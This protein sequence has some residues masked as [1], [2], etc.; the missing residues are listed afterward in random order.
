MIHPRDL[1]FY[2]GG[3]AL[4]KYGTFLRRTWPA[5]LGG[6]ERLETVTRATRGTWV[7]PDTFIRE[8]NTGVLRVET[9]S[10]LPYT[11]HEA[12]R[13]QVATNPQSPNSWTNI[14]TPIITP[15]QADPFGGTDAILIEDDD[16]AGPEGKHTTCVFT[17]DGTK[18]VEVVLAPGSMAAPRLAVFDNTAGVARHDVSVTWNGGTTPPTVATVTGSGTIFPS[19]RLA[20]GLWKIRITATGV[21]AANT[22]QLRVFGGSVATGTFYLAGGNAFDNTYPSSWQG[23]SLASRNADQV[24]VPHPFVPAAMT[25]YSRFVERAQPNWVTVG[26]VA[27]RML[28]IGG[29]SAGS[30]PQLRIYKAAGGDAYQ[31]VHNNGTGSVFATVDLN[32]TYDVETELLT[33]LNG[34]GAVRIQG[35]KNGGTIVDAGWSGDLPLPGAWSAP[36]LHVASIGAA[37]A[38]DIALYAT[39]GAGGVDYT[40]DDFTA[41]LP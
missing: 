21:V 9:V 23:S 31:I 25:A 10:G 24:V 36:E 2:A 29:P 3:A 20:G 41:L 16:G 22:N 33:M 19:I 28:H 18:V 26:G 6:E 11:L 32:P 27:P 35:R 40:F 13:T 8:V 37:G 5:D 34:A 1:L 14:G 30:T 38:G 4:L 15:G 12:A 7:G 39:I 17:G